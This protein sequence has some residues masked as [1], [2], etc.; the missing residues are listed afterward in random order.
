VSIRHGA[1]VEVNAFSAAEER[2][3]GGLGI[4]FVRKLM[5]LPMKGRTTKIS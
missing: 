5:F 3:V 4:Y 2:P 1:V